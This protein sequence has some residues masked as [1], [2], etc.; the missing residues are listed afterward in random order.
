[1]HQGDRPE[2][3]LEPVDWDALAGRQF[4]VPWRAVVAV[5]AL[6]GLGLVY[7]QASTTGTDPLYAWP[8]SDLTWVYRACVVLV[9]AFGLPPLLTNWPATT[10]RGRQLVRRPLGLASLLVTAGFVLGGLVGPFLVGRPR[11]H[12][13]SALQPPVYATVPK[14]TVAIHCL[15][16]VGG[17][18]IDPVCY[19]TWQHPLGT[20]RTGQDLVTLVVSGLHVS[21]E[22][23]VVA[24]V[25]MVPIATAVGLAAGYL[26]G[27]VDDVLMRYVDVQG[28]V[29]AFV[30][31]IVL[32]FLWGH[33][34][35]LLVVVFGLVSWGSLA[36]LVRSEAI[37]RRESGYVEAARS[38]GVGPGG[39]VRRH[40][41]PNV[42]SS[43]LVGAT[44]QIPQL[45]LVATAVTFIGLG[46]VG[47]WFQS[48]GE[49]IASGFG[50]AFGH[51]PPT[52]WWTWVVPVA[53]LAVVVLGLL[54]LGDELREV[55]DPRG[56]W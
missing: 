50:L 8:A 24:T 3:D 15:G 19:G 10:R 22:V 13:L 54:V 30:V 46:D 12:I 33:S 6:L 36:R 9:L 44:G 42:S 17:T 23:A 32:A 52:V 11:T 28:A 55:L 26:G 35:L 5:L 2:D 38:A 48:F 53:A 29:P 47:R 18:A 34:L 56:S 51:Q 40:V 45:V 39:I 43:I 20:T 14:G 16:R 41:L 21:L 27:P 25:L 7:R 49:T 37:Q 31:Y 1:M 4:R